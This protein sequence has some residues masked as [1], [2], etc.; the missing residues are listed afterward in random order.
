MAS[1]ASRRPPE[2]LTWAVD[3]LG[4]EPGK[5]VLEVG[6]GRGVAAQLICQRLVDGRLLAIDRSATAVGAA[7]VRN[8]EAVSAGKAHFVVAALAD[9][10]PHLADLADG[11]FAGARFERILAVNV[12]VFWTGTAGPELAVI[13]ELLAPGGELLLVY[14]PPDADH[15]A[16]LE[17]RIPENL[18]HA[19]YR[20]T[21]TR[22]TVGATSVFAACAAFAAFAPSPPYARLDRCRDEDT[23]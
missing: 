23:T 4:V 10:D 7:R 11:A 13:A 22:A 1:L 15:V 5:D 2:R 20:C 21:L 19:G 6:C 14:D 17:A 12:N 18:E 3:A 9:L 16:R 8:A